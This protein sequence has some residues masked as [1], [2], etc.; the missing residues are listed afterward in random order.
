MAMVDVD[1][2]LGLSIGGH[3]ALSLHSSHETVELLHWL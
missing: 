2:W 1:G 3:L